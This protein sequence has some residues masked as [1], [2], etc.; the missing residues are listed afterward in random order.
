MHPSSDFMKAYIQNEK[1]IRHYIKRLVYQSDDAEDIMQ[2]TALILWEKF[3]T[4]KPEYPFTPWAFKIAYN[5]IRNYYRR[6]EKKNA[7]FEETT[8]EQLAQIA[9]SKSTHL[10][11]ILLHLKDCLHK[12]KDSD[13]R[14]VE[15]RYCD[16]GRINDLAKEQKTTPNALSK[17]LQK[18]RRQLFLCINIQINHE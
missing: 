18:I 10:D 7:F 3:E 17:S 6:N 5:E 13:R 12:L 2:A 14:L 1:K 15:Y 4:Y 16:D 8:L 11:E 9:E